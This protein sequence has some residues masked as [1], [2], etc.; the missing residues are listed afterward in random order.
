[1]V[2]SVLDTLLRLISISYDV[3]NGHGMLK[4]TNKV[5]GYEPK[6][7]VKFWKALQLFALSSD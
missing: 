1:M 7:I 4:T 6:M 3:I 5:D 2:I